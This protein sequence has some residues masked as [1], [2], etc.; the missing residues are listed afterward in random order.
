MKR[1]DDAAAMRRFAKTGDWHAAERLAARRG[2]AALAAAIRRGIA[3]LRAALAHRT[4][5]Q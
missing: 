1:D 5:R 2:R 3:R 4:A